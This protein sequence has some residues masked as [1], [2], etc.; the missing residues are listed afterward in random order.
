MAR[1]VSNSISHVCLKLCKS[2]PNLWLEAS[3]CRC[4][5]GSIRI[6]LLNFWAPRTSQQDILRDHSQAALPGACSCA[7]KAAYSEQKHSSHIC[8]YWAPDCAK[9]QPALGRL[10]RLSKISVKGSCRATCKHTQQLYN[11]PVANTQHHSWQDCLWLSGQQ[12]TQSSTPCSARMVSFHHCHGNN[13]SQFAGWRHAVNQRMNCSLEECNRWLIDSTVTRQH[14]HQADFKWDCGS[15]V[16][17][18]TWFCLVTFLTMTLA[19]IQLLLK[20]AEAKLPKAH[21]T[22][23]STCFLE[24]KRQKFTEHAFVPSIDAVQSHCRPHYK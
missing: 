17:S 15:I 2:R 10:G 21:A 9:Y 14:V 18:V 8:I 20:V 12:L 1:H 13:E 23:H 4:T 7:C 3:V 22:Y 11:K 16:L 19:C 6:G 24:K 5:G